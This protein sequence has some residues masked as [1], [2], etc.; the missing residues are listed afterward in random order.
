MY[1]CAKELEKI[2]NGRSVPLNQKALSTKSV[3]QLKFEWDKITWAMASN[4]STNIK[5]PRFSITNSFVAVQRMGGT[6]AERV[7]W[8]NILLRVISRPIMR[9]SNIEC[10]GSYVWNDAG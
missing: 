9:E 3:L 10:V 5:K 1:L 8:E 6:L 2:V 4:Q 7:Q